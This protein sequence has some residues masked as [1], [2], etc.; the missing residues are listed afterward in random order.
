MKPVRILQVFASLDRGGAE[1]M[2]M[3]IYRNIDRNKVQFDFVVNE[4]A[5][6]Y[7]YETEIKKLG[8]RV[9]RIPKYK[10]S[11]Y[12]SYRR[13]W[14]R[15]LTQHPEWKIIHGHHTVPAYIYLGVAKSLNRITIAHSHSSGEKG[16]L[17]SIVKYC[18]RYPIRY[19]STYLFT[20]SKSAARWMFGRK[21]VKAH[22]V[23]NAIDTK[24]FLFSQE[25]RKKVRIEFGLEG[26][27]VVG[28]IG[29][30]HS[31]KN[32]DF[33]VDVFYNVYQKNDNAILMLVGDG[34]L[35]QS[36]VRKVKS[37][38]LC[39]NVVFTG[40]KSE[41]PELLSA[42]DVFVLPSFYE[43]LPVTL[44]EAQASGLPCIISDTITDEVI[45]TGLVE[46]LSI[47]ISP[48][49]WSEKILRLK[50]CIERQ[51]YNKDVLKAGY[52]VKETTKW[53]ENFYIEEHKKITVSNI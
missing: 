14:K 7:S 32:H 40:V 1:T 50:T 33:L 53:L 44:I 8:G 15:L 37:M 39:N 11:N 49:K 28:H 6:K 17:K 13:T 25:K 31:V 43:G 51:S 27:F 3:N 34:E 48:E 26:K 18:S 36:I 41:I 23:K 45:I 42:L 38:G 30:F 5:E 20:C 21:G 52:D 2:I 10:F 9:F 47:N 12:L 46:K 22:V 19:L 35:R 16:S 4:Q 24:K 29:R